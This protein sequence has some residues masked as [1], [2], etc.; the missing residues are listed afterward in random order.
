VLSTGMLRGSA[1]RALLGVAVPGVEGGVKAGERSDGGGSAA[2]VRG[3]EGARDGVE[4]D[5]GEGLLILSAL[6]SFVVVVAV[7]DVGGTESE[8]SS[9]SMSTS[10]SDER[11]ALARGE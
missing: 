3:V 1:R 6:L 7:V 10:L 4:E 9:W 8:R 5:V 11:G 2:W